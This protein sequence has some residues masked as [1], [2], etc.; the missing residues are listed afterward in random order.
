M[1][2]GNKLV[3]LCTALLDA[4]AREDKAREERIAVEQDILTLTG[5]PEE[6]SATTDAPGFKIRVEQK[7]TRKLDDKAWALVVD[8][9]PEAV[10][11]VTTVVEFKIDS[12]GVRWLKEKEP[13]YYKMLCSA[14][15]E[16]PNKPSVKVEVV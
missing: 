3:T 15:T 4:K 2:D 9:I 1:Q 8:Q 16:K 7:I 5:V 12:K 11:P 10:R 13:G 6:G 14:M